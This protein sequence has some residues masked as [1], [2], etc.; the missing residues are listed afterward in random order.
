MANELGLQS[1][2][3]P[4]EY[5]GQGFT[6]VE[7]GIVLEEMGRV[8][9]CAPYFST[10]VLAADAIINAGTDEQK[11]ELLPGIAVGRDDRR[12]RV[13]RAQRQ[14]GRRRH[15]DGGQGLGRQLHARRHEDVRDRRPH[16]RPDRRRGPRSRARAARTASPSSPSTA[17]PPAS[18][19]P[20]SPTM[21]QT[22]KQAKLEFAERGGHAARRARR[23]LGRAVEDARPGRGRCRPT[24]WSAA[25]RRCSRCRSSTPRSACSSVARSARS[26]R[27]STSAPTCSSRSSRASRPRT[28]RRGPRPRTTRSCPVAASLA[29]AYCSDAYFHAAAENIQIH[30]GIG[31]TWEHDAH[32]Y[33]KRAKSSEILLGDATYHRELLAQRI[34]I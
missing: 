12:A 6:F 5:G 31:F 26:R 14:V 18:P 21:D 1:L 30:G 9:L 22:R 28:T 8:L 2:H 23:R 16:R 27:S 32:L 13:H 3:I 11:A 34:G 17:T 24:R 7:L 15:R 20:R 10:V 25:R 19:A 4:E 29:K 33:F